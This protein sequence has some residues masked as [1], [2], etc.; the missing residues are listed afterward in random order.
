M[1]HVAHSAPPITPFKPYNPNEWASATFG[2]D[3]PAPAYRGL[4]DVEMRNG[5]SPARLPERD[6][7]RAKSEKRDVVEKVQEGEENRPIGGGAVA[8]V[9]RRRQREWKKGQSR[10]SESEGEG[11][12]SVGHIQ[13]RGTDV[14]GRKDQS[15][16]RSTVA[17]TRPGRPD[18][19]TKSEHH[20]S[21]HMPAPAVR[22]SEI[23]AILLG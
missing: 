1:F 7:E 6:K 3:Q 23:P 16:E 21:F 4:E 2:F 14:G 12:V 17:Q 19:T 20:Y 22:H 10:G 15:G 5:D 9:R 8:R 11:Q 18:Q 13:A